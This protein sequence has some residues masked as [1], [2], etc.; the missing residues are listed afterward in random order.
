MRLALRSNLPCFA[1]FNKIQVPILVKILRPV[2]EPCPVEI[3]WTS[4]LKD[5]L[6]DKAD[7]IL[8]VARRRPPPRSA[9]KWIG[10]N[11]L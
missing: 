6:L 1:A 8:P 9:F 3:L 2:V 7:T 11:I 4:S 10:G 5:E